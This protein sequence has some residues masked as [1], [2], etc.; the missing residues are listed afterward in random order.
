MV[1]K[2]VMMKLMIFCEVRI[3]SESKIWLS[4][5]HLYIQR[6]LQKFNMEHCIPVA[7]LLYCNQILSND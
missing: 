5:E 2:F 4:Q 1:P 3:R 6:L 7:T